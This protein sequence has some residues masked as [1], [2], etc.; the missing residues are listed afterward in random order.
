MVN[1]YVGECSIC[2]APVAPLAGV[3]E[4]AGRGWSVKHL[5][6]ADRGEPA[7]DT[8]QFGGSDNTVYIR[9]KK[10]RCEDAPCCGCCTI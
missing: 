4:R 2:G 6:C 5:A 1:K 10:G 3:L 8:F 7:V 9:N